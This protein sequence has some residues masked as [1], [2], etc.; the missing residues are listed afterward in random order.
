MERIFS[1][2]NQLASITQYASQFHRRVIIDMFFRQWDEDKYANLATMLLNNYRQALH[3]IDEDGAA[4][5]DALRQL[6]CG[7]DTIVQWHQE[8]IAYFASIG[9]EDSANVVAVEYVTLLRDLRATE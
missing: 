6:K 3:I 5:E 8:E 7:P 4:V 2:S 1:A 9:T